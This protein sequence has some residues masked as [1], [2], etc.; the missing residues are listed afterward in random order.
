MTGIFGGDRAPDLE[1]LLILG[2]HQQQGDHRR[3]REK[4]YERSSNG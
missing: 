4:N 2:E 1:R 3:D